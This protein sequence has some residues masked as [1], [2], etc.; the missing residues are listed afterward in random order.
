MF[1]SYH[2]TS[3][4]QVH[5]SVTVE[6]KQRDVKFD[7]LKKVYEQVRSDLIR[8]EKIENNLFSGYI[9]I[10]KTYVSWNLKN[11]YDIIIDFFLNGKRV[12]INKIITIDEFKLLE[13][14]ETLSKLFF[15]CVSREITKELLIK[16]DLKNI[17]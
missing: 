7:D 8:S 16:T 3:R 1:N 9:H 2:Y 11:Q 10:F 14:K 5:T 17:L 6:N 15:D 4:P 13:N 12:N